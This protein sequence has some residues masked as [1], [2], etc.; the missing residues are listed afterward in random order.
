VPAVEECRSA[1]V[2]F[3]AHGMCEV[4]INGKPVTDEVLLPGFMQ[5]NA[6]IP[7]REYSVRSL[8]QPGANVV[9]VL[10]ADGWFRGQNGIPRAADQWGTQTSFVAS[11][12]A[13]FQ[14]L[15]TT[16][17]EWMSST[18]HIACAD[19]IAGQVEDRCLFDSDVHSFTYDVSGWN[20]VEVV[21]TP[22]ATLVP[23]DVPPVRRIE[24][25]PAKSVE[26]IRPGVFIVDFGQNLNGWCRFRNLGPRGTRSVLTHAE[27]LALDGDI[28]TK[29]LAPIVPIIP[30]KLTAGMIDEVCSSGVAGDM[31][32]PSFTTHGFRYVRIEGHPGPISVDDIDA[33]AVHSDLARTGWFTCDNERI[34]KL[35]EAAV[36]SMRSNMTEIPT[37]CPQRE[38]SGW[39]GDWQLFAPTAAFLYDVKA[40]TRKWLADVRIDQR[41]DGAV[42]NISPSTRYEGFDGPLAHLSGS[43]GWGDVVV[44]GPLA[45]YEAYGDRTMLDENTDAMRRWIEFGLKTA[46]TGRSDDRIAANA[47]PPAHEKYLWDTGFHW[48]EWLEPNADLRDFFAFLKADKSEVASAYLAH[49]C[50]TMVDICSDVTEAAKYRKLADEI[51]SAWQTEFLHDGLP[52]TQTQAAHVRALRFGL[53]DDVDRHRV[54]A[55]LVELIRD[56]GTTVGTGFLSTVFLLPVLADAGYVDVAYELLLQGQMPGWMYM[57]DQGATT[58]WERWEGVDAKGRPHESL[59]HYSKAAVVSFLHNYTAGLKPMSPGYDTFSVSPHPGGGLKKAD[60]RFDSRHG[61]IEVHWTLGDRFDLSVTVPHGTVC[62]V[63]MPSG[64]QEI[65]KPGTHTFSE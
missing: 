32:E 8:L 51:R 2:S 65:V 33:V 54:A 10:L 36:W 22:T 35:H 62:T 25:V 13:G 9:A 39:V 61:T 15:C 16:S 21:D 20:A 12:T 50:A 40:F 41:A 24:I 28:T 55:R 31:F 52:I 64:Q 45:L 34:N 17:T 44:F 63:T 6:R 30:E 49:S 19:L 57:I 14:S 27:W 18:S 48:G 26:E 3:S 11:I 38:R 47:V 53:V 56:A 1:V 59:N 42:A 4:Y 58:V 43:A 37:D 5:Y 46:A 7:F 23:Y 29:H 60:L